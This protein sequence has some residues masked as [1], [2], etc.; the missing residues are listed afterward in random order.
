[1]FLKKHAEGQWPN[2]RDNVADRGIGMMFE[3]R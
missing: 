3:V 2:D 1:M